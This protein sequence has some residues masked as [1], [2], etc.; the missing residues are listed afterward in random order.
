MAFKYNPLLKEC[1]QKSAD[2]ES[3]QAEIDALQNAINT[4]QNNL[5]AL[6]NSKITKVTSA[7][8]LSELTDGE[9]FEWQAATTQDFTQGYFYKVSN[10]TYTRTDAQPNYTLPTAAAN[11]LGGVKVG[12]GLSIDNAG[13]LSVS[14]GTNNKVAKC[15]STADFANI[16]TDEIFQWQGET[17]TDFV[18]GYF[19][20]KTTDSHVIPAGANYMN[21]PDNAVSI[22]VDYGGFN[23][24][25]GYYTPIDNI[26]T[27][28][29]Y[30]YY[31]SVDPRN[32]YITYL[33]YFPTVVGQK[34]C[35]Y[36]TQNNNAFVG[37]TEVATVQQAS[38]ETYNIPATFADGVSVYSPTPMIARTN[39]FFRK[40]QN[41]VDGSI[42]VC[43]VFPDTQ[44]NKVNQIFMYLGLDENDVLYPL[45]ANSQGEYLASSEIV[46]S[47]NVF[48]R[49]NAQPQQLSVVDN[50][51]KYTLSDNTTQIN[52]VSDD[53]ISGTPITFT[54][55]L[56][57]IRPN[58]QSG[59]TI[60]Q[61]AKV[62]NRAF[63]ANSL[64]NSDFTLNY[65]YVKSIN[66]YGY[67]FEGLGYMI[68]C[69]WIRFN[70]VSIPRYSELFK[71]KD[72]QSG[73]SYPLMSSETTNDLL[74]LRGGE[75]SSKYFLCANA[76]TGNSNLYY[77]GLP[78][79][80]FFY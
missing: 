14:G 80:L 12:N 45:R 52:L 60:A 66:F 13:V 44:M 78:T 10:G 21:I 47:E 74:K 2:I 7:A 19:Y 79:I 53:T 42:I 26:D 67:A 75:S 39:S 73:A 64:L 1:L 70:D 20:K 30:G 41:V 3:I 16:A 9:I 25:A 23:V 68:L 4:L 15:T 46:I 77:N 40:Y 31:R 48:E 61:I 35:K 59:Y 62:I 18:N 54:P 51:V 17:T 69:G 36:D 57:T 8:Q 6:K 71:Y 58:I 11:T 72:F 65:Q 56:T 32:N 28:T 76:M 38:G 22:V 63:G 34:V 49:T 50:Q 55:D 27:P 29:V 24:N 43:G 33:T 37:F 5:N